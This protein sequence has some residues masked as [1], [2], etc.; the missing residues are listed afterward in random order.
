MQIISDDILT[1][2]K[3]VICHQVNCMGKMGSGIALA[4]RNKWPQV[5]D[6]YMEAYNAG[7]LKLGRVIFT[8]VISERLIV[9]SLCGQ[10][11]YGR[12]KCYTD[13]DAVKVCLVKILNRY[14]DMPIYIPYK[15]SCGLAGGNWNIVSDTINSII[16][17][18]IIVHYGG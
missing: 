14:Y 11:R 10:Y 12:G 17:H 4:I 13:Y 15:M 5:Y 1:I 18:A 3:G 7:Q 8:P 16:P 2:T 6:D 9:A